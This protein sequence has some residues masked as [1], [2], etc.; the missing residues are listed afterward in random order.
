M[1]QRE[2]EKIDRE[3]SRFYVIYKLTQGFQNITCYLAGVGQ[4]PVTPQFFY[5]LLPSP[6]PLCGPVIGFMLITVP[7]SLW[8]R[9]LSDRSWV[10]RWEPR[11]V[12]ECMALM[13]DRCT[14][15][16]CI[17]VFKLPSA[18]R[19]PNDRRW[20]KRKSKSFTSIHNYCAQHLAWEISSTTLHFDFMFLCLKNNLVDIWFP[21]LYDHTVFLVFMVLNFHR[22]V[23]WLYG[24]F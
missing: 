5:S 15:L 10:V 19:I 13:T 21:T 8:S 24:Y 20:N 18:V 6:G 12:N 4:L 14:L 3:S 11:D 22:F 1:R 17:Y 23:W 2:R 16:V 7:G 9:G